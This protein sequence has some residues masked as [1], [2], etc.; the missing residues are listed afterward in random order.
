MKIKSIIFCFCLT[1]F[2]QLEVVSQNTK[3]YRPYYAL[4]GGVNMPIGR[5]A[6]KAGDHAGFGKVGRTFTF[7]YYQP[8]KIVGWVLALNY[9]RV[10]V[11]VPSLNAAISSQGL[12]AQEGDSSFWMA[13]SLMGGFGQAW[14]IRD[15]PV[16]LDARLLSGLYFGK[17]PSVN[18]SDPSRLPET[19]RRFNNQAWECVG[20]LGILAGMGF[21][22]HLDKHTAIRI[23]A[24]IQ[25]ANPVYK[26]QGYTNQVVGGEVVKVP[27]TWKFSQPTTMVQFQ[28]GI[29]WKV[30][31]KKQ[32]KKGCFC[33]G[34]F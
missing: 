29:I 10:P 8:A 27:G 28:G 18:F 2:T 25:T 19:Y 22:Y 14:A 16:T 26:I 1:L 3:L 9:G 15:W 11:N 20:S 21:N 4:G 6:D 32:S 31:K 24:T 34:A 13:S 23:S 30:S 12:Q 33:R 17:A 7:E 5:F